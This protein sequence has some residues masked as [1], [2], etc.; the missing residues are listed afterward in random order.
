MTTCLASDNYRWAIEGICISVQERMSFSSIRDKRIHIPRKYHR[1]LEIDSTNV[2]CN[3]WSHNSHWK[4]RVIPVHFCNMTIHVVFSLHHL[5]RVDFVWWG[6]PRIRRAADKYT[7]GSTPWICPWII[8]M[9]ALCVIC[10]IR[11][12]S[13]RIVDPPAEVVSV[14]DV[15]TICNEWWARATACRSATH[16]TTTTA[17]ASHK[18][19]NKRAEWRC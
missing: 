2:S 16:G 13:R 17:R 1:N 6:A 5:L 18:S 3:S 4:C 9:L 8:Y 7:G 14:Q 11:V 15:T 19:G 12:V 10:G